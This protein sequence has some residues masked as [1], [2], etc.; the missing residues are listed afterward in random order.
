MP[1]QEYYVGQS[2]LYTSNR[3][4]KFVRMFPSRH[5]SNARPPPNRNL[6]TLARTGKAANL[7]SKDVQFCCVSIPDVPHSEVDIHASRMKSSSFRAMC[8]SYGWY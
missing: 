2:M 3:L 4:K 5:V 8:S 7:N 1:A 6:V